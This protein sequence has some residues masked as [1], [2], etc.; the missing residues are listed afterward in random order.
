VPSERWMG[1]PSSCPWQPAPLSRWWGCCPGSRSRRPSWPWYRRPMPQLP[2]GN[3]PP[4]TGAVVGSPRRLY[5]GRAAGVATPADPGPLGDP[6]YGVASVDACDRYWR[7]RS[8]S[9]SCSLSAWH[10]TVDV[11]R[12]T[13]I[14]SWGASV[15]AARTAAKLE[16]MS[17]FNADDPEQACFDARPRGPGPA[18]H[19]SQATFL[20]QCRVRFRRGEAAR[21]AT[22]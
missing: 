15:A 19:R 12:C 8:G 20:A 5:G 18:G 17:A 7:E 3:T 21:P 10:R 14:S 13:R 22:I 4:R 9:S 6:R 11:M 1:D 16:P 2:E